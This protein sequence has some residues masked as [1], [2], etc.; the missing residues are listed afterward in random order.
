MFFIVLMLIGG[1]WERNKTSR[2]HLLSSSPHLYTL[3]ARGFSPRYSSNYDSVFKKNKTAAGAD[4]GATKSSSEAKKADLGSIFGK[5]S[6]AGLLL[7][8]DV[9]TPR[10]LELLMSDRETFMKVLAPAAPAR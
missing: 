5:S 2:S 10:G 3:F 7:P 4:K 9:L 6:K 8:V 1:T